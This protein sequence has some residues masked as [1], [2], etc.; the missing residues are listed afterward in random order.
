MKKSEAGASLTD[1]LNSIEAPRSLD[2]EP[3]RRNIVGAAILQPVETTPGRQQ[4][5][6]QTQSV[7]PFSELALRTI[8][9]TLLSRT[10][11]SAANGTRNSNCDFERVYNRVGAYS[12]G[13]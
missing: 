12:D 13:L 4:V 5:M 7:L 9:L 10:R 11:P 6:Q 1:F 3:R 8:A 2:D